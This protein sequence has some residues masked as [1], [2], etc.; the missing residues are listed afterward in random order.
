M[1]GVGLA[2]GRLVE[3]DLVVLACGVRPETTL[4]RA[5]GLAVERGVLVDDQLTT[6]DP[7][8]FALGECSQHRGTVHGLVAPA[9]E[10][11]AVLAEVLTGGDA[12]YTGSRTVARLKAMDLDVAAMGDVTPGLEDCRDGV[13]VLQFADP[14]RHVYKKLVVTDGVVTGAVLLGDLSTVGAV[15]QAFDR[16]TVLP[17]ERLHLLFAGLSAGAPAEP[18]DADVVCTCNAVTAGALRTCGARTVPEAALATRATT[19]CGTC[20]SSVA[21]LLRTTPE[22][23]RSAS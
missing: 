15:T 7:D 9:W 5:A 18:E 23:V 6:S 21:A 13:E 4:A 10:Q 22:L 8:V 2:D 16:G 12:A 1:T 11:A 3:G 17:A 14:V 19:G 20:T